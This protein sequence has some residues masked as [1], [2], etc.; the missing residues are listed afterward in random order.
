M[1]YEMINTKS[2]HMAYEN[3]QIWKKKGVFY[4]IYKVL[5]QVL[6]FR[7]YQKMLHQIPLSLHLPVTL[8]C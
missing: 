3:K 8:S 1:K 6:P 4:H 2:E 5:S 7:N